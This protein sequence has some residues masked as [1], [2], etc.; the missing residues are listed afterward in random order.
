MPTQLENAVAEALAFY[1]MGD[2]QANRYTVFVAADVSPYVGL[3][4]KC[5]VRR[6][7]RTRQCE[8]LRSVVRIY[9]ESSSTALIAIP[10][11]FL[12]IFC[13]WDFVLD[14]RE[15]ER[16]QRRVE[17]FNAPYLKSSETRPIEKVGGIRI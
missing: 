9:W 14:R 5:A 11:C 10:K 7:K 8:F 16:H 4:I 12:P 13:L 1:N 6:G 15:L 2:R 3:M 17:A